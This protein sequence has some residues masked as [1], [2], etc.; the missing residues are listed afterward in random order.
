MSESFGHT[1]IAE[2]EGRAPAGSAPEPGDRVRIVAGRHRSA[3]GVLEGIHDVG[4]PSGSTVKVAIVRRP[5][6]GATIV[7]SHEIERA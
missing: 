4:T 1:A 6:A 5:R 3:A 7:F 2:P